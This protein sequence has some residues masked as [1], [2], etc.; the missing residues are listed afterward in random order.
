MATVNPPVLISHKNAPRGQIHI[1][2]NWEVATV[3]DLDTLEPTATD[4]YKLAIV[5]GT[6]PIRVYILSQVAPVEWTLVNLSVSH[7]HTYYLANIAARDD[8]T[9]VANLPDG[10][11][12]HVL[13]SEGDGTGGA[14]EATY[15]YDLSAGLFRRINTRQKER[16]HS[17]TASINWADGG[18]QTLA[19]TANVT[20]TLTIPDGAAIT[21]HITLGDTW[22]I[23][24]PT[25]KWVGGSAPTLTA[26]DVVEVW[27]VG[28]VIYGAYVGSVV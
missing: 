8:A 18:I 20:V 23:T 21:L 19:L 2:H 14:G 13:D 12:V 9:F 24:W 1:A 16:V 26:D 17:A 22:T 28:G 7:S 4:L 10:S 25:M 11:L 3:P 27:A 6:N 15:A 5:T